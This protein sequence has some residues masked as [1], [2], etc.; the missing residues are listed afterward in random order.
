MKLVRRSAAVWGPLAF[1]GAAVGAAGLQPGYSHRTHHI[2]GLAAAGQR[3]S[4]LMV[5]GFVALAAANLLM[6]MRSTP[7]MVLTRACGLG[8]LT[9]GLIPASAPHCPR[10]GIDP[11]A[12]RIDMIHTVASVA[13]FIGW[14]TR[15]IV[16]AR[17]DGPR[18]F[19]RISAVC[20]VTT[21][22][23]LLIAG[24]TTQSG[25]PRRGVAQR[26]FLA[27]VFGWQLIASI[28][29]ASPGRGDEVP[30]TW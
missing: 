12:T 24:A 29:G 14:T 8:V 1:A 25:S 28:A 22:V 20:A 17:G 18:W 27:S 10:P 26:T 16:A 9:A 3:S 5:P 11:D 21:A 6:P 19:R 15:P 30:R 7:T 23:S 13:T 2:S 4:A